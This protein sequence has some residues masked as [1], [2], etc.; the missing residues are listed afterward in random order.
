MPIG[1]ALALGH[2]I[3]RLQGRLEELEE[4]HGDLGYFQNGLQIQRKR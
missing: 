2:L 1:F 4:R 3:G